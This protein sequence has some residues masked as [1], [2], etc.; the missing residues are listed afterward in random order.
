MNL[1][2]KMVAVALATGMSGASAGELSVDM[3]K[4]TKD[5]LG[6]KIGTVVLRDTDDHG[7]MIVPDLTGL[8]PGAH[9]FHIHEKPDCGSGE[10]DGKTVPGLAAGGHFDPDGS[11]RHEGP[12][13]NGHLG[14][15]PQLLV[16]PDGDAK[17]PVFAPRLST[18]QVAKHAL[19]IHAGGDNY[20]DDPKPLGG[21]GSRAACGIIKLGGT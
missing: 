4:L 5:G 2:K 11:G 20:S 13:G 19:M 7:L 9:G 8:K 3:H 6:E 1:C 14:D 10:K 12:A 17:L 21:G 18:A 16:G 15:L